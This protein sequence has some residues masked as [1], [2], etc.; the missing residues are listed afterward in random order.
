MIAPDKEYTM[1]VIQD[2]PSKVVDTNWGR[3][4]I[5]NLNFKNGQNK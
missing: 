1:I 4:T 5:Y 3:E 2:D